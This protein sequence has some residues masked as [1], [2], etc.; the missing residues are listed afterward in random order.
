MWQSKWSNIRLHYRR[1]H[2]NF[3]SSKSRA[4]TSSGS[5]LT[6]SCVAIGR[7]LFWSKGL[8]DNSSLCQ[9][10][11]MRNNRRTIGDQLLLDNAD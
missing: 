5:W 9:F 2:W 7:V 1:R 8:W 4:T 6:S 3:T 11:V 10:S